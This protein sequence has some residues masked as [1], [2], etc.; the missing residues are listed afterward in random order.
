MDMEFRHNVLL[1]QWI[2]VGFRRFQSK[3]CWGLADWPFIRV[4]WSLSWKCWWLTQIDFQQK[5]PGMEKI[6]Q[7]R[8]DRLRHLQ[9]RLNRQSRFGPTTVSFMHLLKTGFAVSNPPGRKKTHLVN[10]VICVQNISKQ[11]IHNLLSERKLYKTHTK[12]T[13]TKLWFKNLHLPRIIHHFS[14]RM[15]GWNLPKEIKLMI[16]QST[17]GMRTSHLAINQLEHGALEDHM[18]TN[19]RRNGYKKVAITFHKSKS[20]LGVRV[21]ILGLKR[22]WSFRSYGNVWDDRNCVHWTN[23]FTIT[24][25][26]TQGEQ[27]PWKNRRDLWRHIWRLIHEW[28]CSIMEYMHRIYYG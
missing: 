21:I 22:L 26:D 19:K 23:E 14:A 7:T 28:W 16:C 13:K 24:F 20:I 2:L 12:C 6:Q 27:F 17:L 15:P 11:I 4:N 25:F 5:L 18:P 1:N 10:P 3:K 8:C 9:Y